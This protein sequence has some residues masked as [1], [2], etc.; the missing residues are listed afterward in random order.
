VTGLAVPGP[1]GSSGIF[2]GA[3]RFGIC[4]PVTASPGTLQTSSIAAGENGGGTVADTAM[5]GTISYP[6]LPEHPK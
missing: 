6:D 5:R 1:P 3:M 4:G 2:S